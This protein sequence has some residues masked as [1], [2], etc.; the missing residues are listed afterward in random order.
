MTFDQFFQIVALGACG[1]VV[2]LLGW[3]VREVL[4]QKNGATL[5]KQR[6]D[7]HTEKHRIYDAERLASSLAMAELGKHLAVLSER[8]EGIA[9]ALH[10]IESALVPSRPK[11]RS[12]G[13]EA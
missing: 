3:T 12:R 8:S 9:K 7:D 10:R 2:A 11:S 5:L 13:E 1:I 6:V 4:A